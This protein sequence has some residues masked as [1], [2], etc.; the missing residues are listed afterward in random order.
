MNG[1]AR[2]RTAAWEF[3]FKGFPAAQHLGK[4]L[5]SVHL[6]MYLASVA[7]NTLI[8]TITRADHHLQAPVYFFLSSFSFLECCFTT[9]VI[10]K[11][12][13]IFL[14]GRQKISFAACITQAFPGSNC[15]LPNGCIILGSV[16]GHLKASLLSNHHEPKDVFPSGHC[17]PSF[18]VLPHGGFSYKAF[19]VIL[20]WLPCH[21]SLL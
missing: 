10:P 13:A 1:D 17:L 12:L 15:F 19:S 5:F 3:T 6:L 4:V 7:G 2:N 16:Y 20:L 9:T 11:L 8:I 14:L 21:S 18:G